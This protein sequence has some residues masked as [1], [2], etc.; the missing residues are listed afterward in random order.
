MIAFI[1]SAVLI[2]SGI[3]IIVFNQYRKGPGI[4]WIIAAFAAAAAWIITLFFHWFPPLPVYLIG[5]NPVENFTNLIGF[6]MDLLAWPYSFALVSLI[7]SVIFSSSARIEETVSPQFWGFSLVMTGFGV[8][9][10]I[11]ATPLSL[12]LTWVL[13]DISELIVLQRSVKNSS[14]N[15]AS[16]FSFSFRMI[17][18]LLISIAMMISR[19]EGAA[20]RFSNISPY[21]GLLLFLAVLVRIGVIPWHIYSFSDFRFR[22]EPGILLQYISASTA[23]ILLARLPDN[24]L[25]GI[26][27]NFFKALI[28]LA[29]LYCAVL[30]LLSENEIDAKPYWIMSLSGLAVMSMLN[31]YQITSM[32][33]GLIMILMG[34]LVGLYTH[35]DAKVQFIAAL[36]ILNFLGLPFTPAAGAWV[37]LLDQPFSLFHVLYF[38]IHVLL[39]L[40]LV[41]HLFRYGGSFVHLER[42]IQVVYPAGLMLLILSHWIIATWGWPGSYTAGVWW[43]SLVPIFLIGIG[44]FIQSRTRYWEVHADVFT[45]WRERVIKYFFQPISRFLRF[46]WVYDIFRLL[47]GLMDRIINFISRLLEGEGAFLWVMLLLAILVTFLFP[48]RIS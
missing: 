35:R 10:L 32:V 20:L 16:V 25:P 3:S 42:W 34:S 21:A 18:V 24:P 26:S 19:F 29:V 41:K 43:S 17:S 7:V 12:I 6:H 9:A 48:R 22:R 28:S 1:P 2:L 38:A 45:L 33:W 15:K 4:P 23:L 44:Y 40:G 46:S 30:W 5:W 14:E 8:L 31:G 11:A 47:Y 39:I 37:G 13:I 27:L 36:A